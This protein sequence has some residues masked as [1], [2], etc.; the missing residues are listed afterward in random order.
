MNK[1]LF[2][3]VGILFT[4]ALVPDHA[5]VA[6]QPSCL[7][8]PSESPAEQLRRRQALRIAREI[9]SAQVVARRQTNTYQPLSRLDHVDPPPAGFVA[10]VAVDQDGYAFS[11]KDTTD[12]CGFVYF[13]DQDGIIYNGEALR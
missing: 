10:H 9:N 2:V 6:Q 7:H 1:S 13:S 3:V 4:V 8:G 12:P 5:V 11:I